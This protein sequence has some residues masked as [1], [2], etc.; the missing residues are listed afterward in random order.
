M[1]TK[2]GQFNL[3]KLSHHITKL[4]A[5]RGLTWKELTAATGVTASTI[6]RFETAADAEADGVLA[7]IGW[8]DLTPEHFITNTSV[9]GDLLPAPGDGQIRVDMALVDH[10]DPTKQRPTTN[11]RTTIQRLTSV[12]Q[13]SGTAIAA[14]TRW[15]PI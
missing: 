10:H 7:L 12:A 4:R 15:S 13:G 11:T 5:E 6:R 9:D 2:P 8:V 3:N 1:N 14:L